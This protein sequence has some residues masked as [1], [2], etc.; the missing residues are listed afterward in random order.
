MGGLR[1]STGQDFPVQLAVGCIWQNQAGQVLQEPKCTIANSVISF[2]SGHRHGLLLCVLLYKY[3]A[4]H[5]PEGRGNEFRGILVRKAM[6]SIVA[7]AKPDLA[8][9]LIC[10][11]PF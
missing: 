2:C 8:L 1:R 7:T 3:S 4:R 11:S 6:P 10:R 5:H 9:H